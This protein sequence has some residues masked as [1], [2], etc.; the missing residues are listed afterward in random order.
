MEVVNSLSTLIIAISIV[1]LVVITFYYVRLTGCL[2]RA[3]NQPEIVVIKQV[4]KNKL[5][6]LINAYFASLI[7]SAPDERNV[8][9]TR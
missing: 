2:L 9:S 8:Y 5:H 6:I 7:S 3:T 1:A 4:S